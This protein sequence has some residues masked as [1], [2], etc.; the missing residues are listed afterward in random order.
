MP[1][2]FETSR[3]DRLPRPLASALEPMRRRRAIRR[4]RN[5]RRY[6]ESPEELRASPLMAA[7]WYYSVELLPGVVATGQYPHDVPHLPRLALR[8]CDVAG[9]S[10]LDVGTM[11]GLVPT[12][13][14]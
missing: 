3:V 8:R 13:L 11:E 9:A 1:E 14:V 12:L 5:G 6:P 4:F 10:C 2:P 7:R